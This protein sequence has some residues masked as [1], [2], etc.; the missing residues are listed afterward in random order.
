M[1]LDFGTVNEHDMDVL[2]LNAFA[3]D[4][5]FLQM[6]IDK[7]DLPKTDYSIIEVCLSKTDKDGESDI[8]VVIEG[9]GKKYGLLIE[10]KID[11]Q[12]MPYQQK[13]YTIRGEKAVKNNEYDEYKA[14]IVCSKIYY[15]VN[16]EAKK[17]S[18]FVSYEEC[19]NCLERSEHLLAEVWIQQIKQAITKS[20]RHS[21][22]EV[23]ETS[24]AFYNKYKDFQELNHP[25]LDLRTDRKGN[26]WWAQYATRYKNVYLYHKIPQGYV[27][28]TFPDAASKMDGLSN[29]ARTMNEAY[30]DKLR[31]HGLNKIIALPTGKAGALRIDVPKFEMTSIRFEDASIDDIERCFYA[32]TVFSEYANMLASAADVTKP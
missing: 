10:D 26:G 23:D 13:S 30:E 18:Y 28:L 7:T 25:Q 14:F 6:F 19:I 11:A 24:N 1:K 8:T 12:A 16:E 17:Y 27:D 4:K 2:F 3:S 20:K 21:E 29:I 15:T 5:R 9:L 22:T 32:L 31:L